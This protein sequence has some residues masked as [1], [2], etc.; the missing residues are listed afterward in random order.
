MQLQAIC[1]RAPIHDSTP[2]SERSADKPERSHDICGADHYCDPDNRLP[3]ALRAF[4]VPRERPQCAA[5]NECQCSQDPRGRAAQ[6]A[7]EVL[8]RPS[9]RHN[10]SADRRSECTSRDEDDETNEG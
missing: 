3:E 1:L 9:P 6:I 10:R 5:N 8:E 2:P 4:L 7:E